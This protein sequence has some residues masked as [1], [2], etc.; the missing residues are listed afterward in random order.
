MPRGST[1][2]PSALPPSFDDVVT[3][4]CGLFVVAHPNTGVRSAVL[5]ALMDAVD[6]ANRDIV[7][8][9]KTMS[10]DTTLRTIARARYGLRPHPTV[11]VLEDVRVRSMME[12]ALTAGHD[13][14]AV[15]ALP[16]QADPQT[17]LTKI[18]GILRASD[19]RSAEFDLF[20]ESFRGVLQPFAA[21][22]VAAI[23]ARYG[24]ECRRGFAAGE[25][26][27][28]RDEDAYEMS[29]GYRDGWDIANA[30][31]DALLKSL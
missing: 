12:A 13:G 10:V 27:A 15:L 29:P 4:E 19:P 21:D 16:C 17:I 2:E 5:D 25:A 14:V 11:V 30:D 24:A 31:I 6:D 8:L 3:A 20:R 23:A 1:G 22:E 26:G 18:A 7:R 28:P 9:Q